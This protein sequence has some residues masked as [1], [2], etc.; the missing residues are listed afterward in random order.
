MDHIPLVKNI[1]K[2]CLVTKLIMFIHYILVLSVALVGSGARLATG[3][4]PEG[5][6][7][8]HQ[9]FLHLSLS[10]FIIGPTLVCAILNRSGEIEF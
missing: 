6:C 8:T 9:F 10:F 4:S 5:Q 7:Y 1:L 2:N 3:Y